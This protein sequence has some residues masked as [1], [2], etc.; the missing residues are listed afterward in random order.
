VIEG[1]TRR[2]EKTRTEKGKIHK[3]DIA[4][5]LTCCNECGLFH[6]SATI[7][8]VAPRD[9]IAV[10]GCVDKSA[11]LTFNKVCAVRSIAGSKAIAI[12]CFF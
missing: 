4:S 8:V 11:S 6:N 12:F 7:P 1:R 3:R 10:E 5:F 2:Y 9:D